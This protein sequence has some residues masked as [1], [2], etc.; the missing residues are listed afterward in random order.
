MYVAHADGTL[1]GYTNHRSPDRVLQMIDEA[2][3]AYAKHTVN[4]EV[5]AIKADKVDPIYHPELP[6]NGLV[7]RV[8]AKV[9]GGYPPT[10]EKFQQIFQS[11]LSRDNLWIRDDEHRDL[12]RGTVPESLQRRIARFHL[13]DNTR[14][15]PSMWRPEEVRKLVMTLDNGTLMGEVRLATEDGKRG[16]DAVLRGSIAIEDDAITRF[17]VVCRGEFWGTGRYTRQPPPGRFPLAISLTLADGKDIADPIAP[18]GWKVA[19][20][21]YLDD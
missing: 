3:Q 4:P 10:E 13:L 6:A 8:Q 2:Q 18:Q 7:V 14:G 21:R 1:L 5:V 15:E 19:A 12:V 17:D 9:L 16:Y 20:Q 11:A